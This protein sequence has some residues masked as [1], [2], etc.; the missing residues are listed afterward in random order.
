MAVRIKTG[1]N[2]T[3]A[4]RPF[5]LGKD[6]EGRNQCIPYR[7]FAKDRIDGIVVSDSRHGGLTAASVWLRPWDFDLYAPREWL[8]SP[9]RCDGKNRV[10]VRRNA[11]G[12][13]FRAKGSV[14][15]G[16]TAFYYC[17]PSKTGSG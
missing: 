2:I 11:P 1:E 7:F 12:W 4:K 14:P 13:G 10:R 15:Q 8:M 9:S 17:V 3:T 6:S 5:I 16:Q